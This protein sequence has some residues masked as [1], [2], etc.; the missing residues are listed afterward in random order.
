M[1]QRRVDRRGMKLEA[2]VALVLGLLGGIGLA[3]VAMEALN[4][5]SGDA[6]QLRFGFIGETLRPLFTLL[7]VWVWY[8]VVSHVL[9]GQFQERGPISRLLRTSAW[10]LVPIGLWYLIR[11]I[12]TLVLFLDVTFPSNPEGLGTSE[13]LQSLL[14]RGLEDPLYYATLLIGVFFVVWSWYLR[15]LAVEKA[16]TVSEDDARK[17]ATIPTGVF[18]LYFLWNGLQTAGIV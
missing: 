15:S 1:I 5:I 6:A 14:N 16:K 12:V 8:T 17:I 11:S 13:Q 7:V 2:I 3:Y 4:T 10:S 9:A 18:A